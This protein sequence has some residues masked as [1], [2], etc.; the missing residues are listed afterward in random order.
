MATDFLF[1][2]SASTRGPRAVAQEG[3]FLPDRAAP[4]SQENSQRGVNARGAR[5]LHSVN[6]PTHPIVM[7]RHGWAG[8]GRPPKHHGMRV[9]MSEFPDTT[10]FAACGG[11]RAEIGFCCFLWLRNSGWPRQAF[12]PFFTALAASRTTEL[13]SKGMLAASNKRAT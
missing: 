2:G 4:I 6:A 12:S 11:Y 1:A 8:T 13:A 10:N 3:L 7:K 5:H 9:P